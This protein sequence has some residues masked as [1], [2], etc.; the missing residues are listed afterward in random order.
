M[1]FGSLTQVSRLNEQ[2][3]IYL[4]VQRSAR[5]SSD[6]YK[7]CWLNCE[8]CLSFW[9]LFSEQSSLNRISPFVGMQPLDTSFELQ[10][11][12]KGK[13]G[14]LLNPSHMKLHETTKYC[15]KLLYLLEGILQSSST[16]KQLLFQESTLETKKNNSNTPGKCK[17]VNWLVLN[18]P[19]WKNMSQ[20]GNLPQ[21]WVQKKQSNLYTPLFF[22]WHF[23]SNQC[24][25][26]LHHPE[27]LHMLVYWFQHLEFSGRKKKS[28][29]GGKAKQRG[30]W[31]SHNIQENKYVPWLFLVPVIGGRYHIIPQLAAYTTYIPLIYQETPLICRWKHYAHLPYGSKYLLRRYDLTPQIE[32][33]K[34][35]PSSGSL[36][37]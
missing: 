2:I 36:D 17:N 7:C 4:P 13:I 9:Y 27:F 14:A 34:C 23:P 22:P 29:N 26:L 18:Q 19:I 30:W 28:S 20:N 6:I 5:R 24:F 12:H 1:D 35:I 33:Q 25:S 10:V 3:Y 16:V 8:F 37:P 21:I 32:P 11:K 31:G 15:I